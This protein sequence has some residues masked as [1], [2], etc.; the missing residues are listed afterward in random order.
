M[1]AVRKRADDL[2]ISDDE[3]AELFGGL[4]GFPAHVLAVSGGPDST[5]LLW[6]AAR[7]R[8]ALEQPPRLVAVTVD[9]GLRPESAE[10]AAA[11]KQL[12]LSLKVEHRTMQWAG[13]KPT[14][15][16]QAS[17]REA[18]YRLLA[19]A[20]NEAG[21]RHILT[22]HTLDDQ[23]ETIL[24][25]MA[26]GSGLRGLA[27]MSFLDGNPSVPG[28]SLVRPFLTVGKSRLIATLQAA[29]V[30]YAIDPSNADPRFTRPRLRALMPTL[31]R[32]GLTAER[33]AKLARRMERADDALAYLSAHFQRDV[34]SGSWLDGGP[35][36]FD[37]A[38]YQDLPAE[39]SIR[40][41]GNAIGFAG[42]EGT[43]ELAQLETLYDDI[44]RAIAIGPERLRRTLAGALITLDKGKLTVERAPPRRSGAKTDGPDGKTAFTNR[45]GRDVERDVE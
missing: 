3:A 9:H 15:G 22:A 8:D 43:A 7:W 4:T 27:G 21:A 38:R 31:A 35:F 2:P 34:V 11:V 29:K 44:K 5:A 36:A 39:I 25:R 23:A 45:R 20:A 40:I 41:L 30:P 42:K 16:I 18:R 32:E 26:R 10:E 13:T 19:E 28:S 37:L 6:L 33:L 1:P 24:F 12:A 14:T 17:A